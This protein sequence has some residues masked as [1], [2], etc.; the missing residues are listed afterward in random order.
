MNEK[1]EEIEKQEENL[2]GVM[3]WNPRKKRFRVTK[4][5]AEGMKGE[6]RTMTSPLDLANW[7]LITFARAVVVE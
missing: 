3:F 4:V 2:G 6:V 1:Q 5:T 7:S